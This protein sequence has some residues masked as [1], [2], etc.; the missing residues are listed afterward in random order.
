MGI[1]F[2]YNAASPAIGY[3]ANYGL[4]VYNN[5]K[6]SESY[7]KTMKTKKRTGSALVNA[8]SARFKTYKPKAINAWPKGISKKFK[9]KVEKVLDANEFFGEYI[10]IGNIQL[11]QSA[12]DWH[13]FVSSDQNTYPLELFTPFQIWDAASILYN[14]KTPS[15]DT[16]GDIAT[17]VDH[18]YNYNQKMHII[19]SYCKY[20]FKSTS[21]HVVNVEMYICRP[22]LATE[23]NG[24]ECAAASLNDYSGG[25]SSVSVSN[26]GMDIKYQGMNVRHWTTLHKFFHVTKKTVKLLP[27]ESSNVYIKGPSNKTLDGSNLQQINSTSFNKFQP[28]TGAVSVFFRVTNDV[29]V[30]GTV[31]NHVHSFNSNNVGGVACRYERVIRMREPKQ[32]DGIQ[33]NFQGNTIKIGFWAPAK[34]EATDQQ[35]VYQNP[36]SLTASS[37]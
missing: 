10:Y 12:V 37:N 31:T 19:K 13:T 4:Q 14:H 18:N 15:A 29:T 36:V 5:R 32:A 16:H 25:Y 30:G 2:L 35:V 23:N 3:A 8:G 22:K 20:F 7:T 33:T 17:G 34:G 24:Y 28:G 6:P 26:T 27:G 21:N 9:A 11:Y 1:G